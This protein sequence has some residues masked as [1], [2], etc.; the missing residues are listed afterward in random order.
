MSLSDF[1][2]AS[3]SGI[4]NG[5]N[6]IGLKGATASGTG[7]LTDLNASSLSFALTVLSVPLDGLLLLLNDGRGMGSRGNVQS[8]VVAMS[9]DEGLEAGAYDRDLPR[10][11]GVKCVM[12][13]MGVGGALN[14]DDENNGGGEMETMLEARE[15]RLERDVEDA[16]L[17]IELRTELAAEDEGV[18]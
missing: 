9:E 4:L 11:T 6:F 13:V 10:S 18:Y 17:Q 8:G 7:A 14:A 5:L 15:D 1:F 12:G 2:A 3:L 16:T